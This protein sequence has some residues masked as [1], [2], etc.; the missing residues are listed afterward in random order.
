MRL[1]I[2]PQACRSEKFGITLLASHEVW[3]TPWH[4]VAVLRT[5]GR[6][7]LMNRTAAERV[8]ELV[9][10]DGRPSHYVIKHS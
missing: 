6:F 5:D 1:S 4:S 8:G 7:V 9:H 2:H 10:R 3:L